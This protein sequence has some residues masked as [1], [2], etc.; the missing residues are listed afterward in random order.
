[1]QFII[2]FNTKAVVGVEPHNPAMG[3]LTTSFLPCR[4]PVR[5]QCVN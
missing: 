4:G 1:M 3:L 2:F 5:L